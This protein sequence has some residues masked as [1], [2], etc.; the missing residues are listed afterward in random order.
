MGFTAN[1]LSL[2]MSNEG[3][4]EWVKNG[5]AEAAA[6]KARREAAVNRGRGGASGAG[7]KKSGDN[8]RNSN[9]NRRGGNGNSNRGGER[10]AMNTRY[11][12]PYLTVTD[13]KRPAKGWREFLCTDFI[14]KSYSMPWSLAEIKLR[15]DTN[16]YN[17]IGNYLLVVL[18]VFVCVL[19]NRPLALVGGVVTMKMWDWARSGGDMQGS[20]MF[21]F[22]YG[23]ATILSWAVMMYSNVTF[24]VSYAMLISVTVVVVHGV[25]RRL[26]APSPSFA[27]SPRTQNTSLG[28]MHTKD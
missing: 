28:K 22:K 21:Q 25:L 15:L 16:L 9:Q 5:E 26:D 27:R 23:A 13:L 11:K 6:E 1:P 2:S 4:N 24:A 14:A 7:T 17:Y 20:T 3:L 10:G 8:G 12:M 19:Y 18:A